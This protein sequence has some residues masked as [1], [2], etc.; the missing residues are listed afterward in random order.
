[1]VH[2]LAARLI[3]L[4]PTV[5]VIVPEPVPALPAPDAPEEAAA[6]SLEALLAEAHARGVAEGEARAS[7]AHEAARDALRAEAEA[8]L[9]AERARWANEEGA[10]LA[11][12]LDEATREIEA[13]LAAA[14]ARALR[15]FLAEA[16]RERALAGLKEALAV[17][18]RGKPAAALAMTGP[19]DLGAAFLARLAPDV[20]GAIRFTPGEGPELALSVDDTTIETQLAAWARAL[21]GDGT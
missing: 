8:A 16:A 12:A 10:R 11:G 19:A 20:A 18:L 5:A 15:P 3:E 2:P 13:R 17:L 21:R 14:A 6:P 1:M 7:A 9:A 4:K